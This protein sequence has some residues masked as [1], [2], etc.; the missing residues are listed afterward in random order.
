MLKSVPDEK[1]KC[2][3]TGFAQSCRELVMSG[4]CQDRWVDLVVKN[5]QTG[6]EDKRWGCVDDLALSV[7]LSIEARLLG[8]QAATEKRGDMTNSLLMD[9]MMRQ[10]RQHREALGLIDDHRAAGVA[11]AHHAPPSQA[12]SCQADDNAQLDMIGYITEPAKAN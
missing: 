9:T 12:L 11:L 7:N 3:R 6:T 10:E 4:T 1:R 2:P 8:V 5:V